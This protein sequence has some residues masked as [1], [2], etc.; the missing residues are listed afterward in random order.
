[1]FDFPD[2]RGSTPMAA[3]SAVFICHKQSGTIPDRRESASAMIADEL[4][5]MKTRLKTFQCGSSVTSEVT[6]PERRTRYP[7][8]ANLQ[9]NILRV[10]PG[11][12]ISVG[13]E[14]STL[15][16][17]KRA[18]CRATTSLCRAI[19]ISKSCTHSAHSDL[20]YR[21]LGALT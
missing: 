19:M 6:I 7:P 4:R 16:R 10:L 14:Y 2:D 5:Y 18:I 12:V 8:F 11:T 21:S 13:V 17:Q 3:D 9:N 20:N 15:N 1:M